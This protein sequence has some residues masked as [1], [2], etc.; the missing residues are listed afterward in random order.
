MAQVWW[1]ESANDKIENE[2]HLVIFNKYGKLNIGEMQ[3]SSVVL[4]KLFVQRW[5]RKDLVS[6]PDEKRP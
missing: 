3:N 5:I 4:E 1:K 6:S 2:N